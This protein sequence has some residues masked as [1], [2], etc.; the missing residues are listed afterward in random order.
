MKFLWNENKKIGIFICN[1]LDNKIS[2][3]D[4]MKLIL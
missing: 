2:K 4:Q 3:T 1:N